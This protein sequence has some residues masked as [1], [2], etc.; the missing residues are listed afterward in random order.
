MK[1]ENL[2]NIK[3]E[4]AKQYKYA[5]N[6]NEEKKQLEHLLQNE[7]VKDYIRLSGSNPPAIKYQNEDIGELFCCFYNRELRNVKDT[8]TNKIF[9]YAGSYY[10]QDD[11]VN[12]LK[13]IRVK[14]DNPKCDYRM[15]HDLE[16]YNPIMVPVQKCA[17]F[18]ED[19]NVIF[20]DYSDYYNDYYTIRREF[21][22]DILFEGQEK[23]KDYIVKKYVR[24]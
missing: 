23:A 19:N 8:D 17:K 16:Q 21:A 11:K 13:Q 18:E 2:R 1:D 20:G 9:V 4:M 3:Y 12:G 10:I 15:Y 6:Y 5:R 22:T 14:Y 7:Y 24:K